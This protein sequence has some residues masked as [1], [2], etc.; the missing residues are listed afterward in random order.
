MAPPELEEL[1]K[2]LTELLEA[3]HI[4][5]SK[6]PFGAPVLFQ[7][8]KEGKLR[9]CIDYRAL[10]KV[11]VKNKYLIPLIA[12]LFDRLG[13]A[14]VFIKMDLRKGYYQ[15]RI[16][17]G[18]E[19][20]MTWVTRYGAFE[21]LGMPFGLTNAPAT[22]CTLMN[23][24][25]YPFLDQF[26]VIY[27]D[28]IVV[29]NNSLAEHVEHLLQVFEVLGKNELFVKKDKC[30]FAQSYVQFLGHTISQGEIRMD[31]GKV[32]AIRDWEAP[33]KG[34]ELRSLLGLANYY[35][36]F[37]EGYSKIAG[38]LTDSLKKGR[39][40]EWSS[41]CQVLLMSSKQL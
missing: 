39:E 37:I 4:R 38:P 21:W 28:D 41:S 34:T 24:L 10:N 17:E 40:W 14:K 26:F 15:V 8:K 30:T 16:G 7:K 31:R 36:H 23:R 18:D 9:L 27:L 20:K 12:D 29:Y 2:Q 19:P 1:R 33:T 22:F 11:T 32:D 13:Q 6:A 25:F 3:G 5:P 35:R